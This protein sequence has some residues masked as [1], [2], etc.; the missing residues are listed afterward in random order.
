MLLIPVKN[1]IKNT[2]RD[3]NIYLF[4]PSLPGDTETFINYIVTFEPYLG[5]FLLL[6]NPITTASVS[7]IPSFRAK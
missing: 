3:Y 7:N 4:Y 5:K 2:Q 6:S 1:S